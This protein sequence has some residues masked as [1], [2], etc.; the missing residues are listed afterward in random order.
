MVIISTGKTL[1]TQ[2][3]VLPNQTSVGVDPCSRGHKP[4]SLWPF[5]L[6]KNSG[7]LFTKRV[8]TSS[9]SRPPRYTNDFAIM[10]RTA[11]NARRI[12]LVKVADLNTSVFALLLDRSLS[13]SCA[14]DG[15]SRVRTRSPQ[16]RR[17][18]TSAPHFP[19]SSYK[20]H[21]PYARER[22]TQ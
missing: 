8:R 12:A 19:P 15:Q 18:M 20:K 3:W 21:L 14:A 17:T 5:D 10:S 9:Q 16:E 1:T 2:P 22:G 7:V 11:A 13:R 6:K 4:V